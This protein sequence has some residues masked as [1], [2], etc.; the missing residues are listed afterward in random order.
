VRGQLLRREARKREIN[1]DLKPWKDIW[2]SRFLLISQTSTEEKKSRRA[3]A[4]LG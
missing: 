4:G 3:A 1:A 2:R